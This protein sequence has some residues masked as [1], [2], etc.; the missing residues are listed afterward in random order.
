YLLSS[1]SSSLL[2]FTIARAGPGLYP[3][4]PAGAL[5]Q[6]RRAREAAAATE[7]PLQEINPP[8]RRQAE[9]LAATRKQL[10]GQ[11]RLGRIQTSTFSTLREAV[12]A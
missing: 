12:Y 3:S 1:R 2:P 4:A 6:T 9:G 7:M 5:Q 10:D 11:S 8:L